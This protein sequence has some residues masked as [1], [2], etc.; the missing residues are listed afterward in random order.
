MSWAIVLTQRI[1]MHP[2]ACMQ[3]HMCHIHAC[4]HTSYPTYAH[5]PTHVCYMHIYRYSTVLPHICA[6]HI[7]ACTCGYPTHA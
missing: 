5:P 3:A 7:Q 1:H 6:I 2:H 4:M